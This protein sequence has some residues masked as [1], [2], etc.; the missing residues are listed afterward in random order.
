VP[1]LQR[2]RDQL[3][4]EA[5]VLFHR[6]EPWHLTDA[7]IIQAQADEMELRVTEDVWTDPILALLDKQGQITAAEALREVNVTPDRRRTAE[8][9]RIAAILTKAGC[10]QQ[11]LTSASGRRERVWVKR[12]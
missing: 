5:V 8:S 11:R 9:K 10:T 6:G 4:A 7:A 12:P 3:W 1:Y 2:D